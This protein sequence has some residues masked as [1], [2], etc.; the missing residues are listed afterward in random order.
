MSDRGRF[1][2]G[3]AVTVAVALLAGSTAPVSAVHKPWFDPCAAFF[4]DADHRRRIDIRE[5]VH[6]FVVHNMKEDG[7]GTGARDNGFVK[8]TDDEIKVLRDGF[9][10]I[11]DGVLDDPVKLQQ[12]LKGNCAQLRDNDYVVR[13][14]IDTSSGRDRLITILYEI[15]VWYWS[16]PQVKTYYHG[17]G[18]YV[19]G[20]PD[21]SSLA[22]EVPHACA[23]TGGPCD[24]GDNGTHWVGAEAFAFGD[25]RYLFVNGTSRIAAGRTGPCDKGKCPAD[26]AHNV[27]T[28]FKVLHDQAVTRVAKV[29]QP[30][31]FGPM[32][33]GTI[34]CENDPEDL[35]QA[36]VSSGDKGSLS[37]DALAVK[38]ALEAKG[39]AV[40]D[41][42]RN[43]E[44]NA[45]GATGNVERQSMNG[46]SF[47]SVEVQTAINVVKG[48]TREVIADTVACVL[49]GSDPNCL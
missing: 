14:F 34:H 5:H 45:L 35:C 43:P 48:G 4:F 25:A 16:N 42:G 38:A 39:I 19:I 37:P 44:C 8:P 41:Y 10:A 32:T 15:P 26:V 40:C 47:V 6:E 22:V 1:T 46:K 49:T 36:V 7:Y 21:S 3:L 23:G 27:N 18:L 17:W 12:W 33:G 28:M 29:Y 2:F 20:P 24:S 13:R 31:G 9:K 11:S 30:H